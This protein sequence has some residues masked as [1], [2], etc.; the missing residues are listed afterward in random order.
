[1]SVETAF[2]AGLAIYENRSRLEALARRIRFRIK[3]GHLR[4]GVFGLG[5]TGKT[6][7]G[8][9]LVGVPRRINKSV[10]VQEFHLS[11]DLECTLLVAPGQGRRIELVWP[12]LF[13]SVAD[14]S[15]TGVVNVVS[16]GYHSFAGVGFRDHAAYQDGMDE[17]EFLLAYSS[18]RRERE[19]EALRTMTP[20]LKSAPGDLWMITLVT[21][22]D[23][24]WKDQLKV[25]DYY[26]TGEY[27]EL[28][29]GIRVSRGA[30]HFRHEYAFAS[31]VMNNLRTSDG[32]L[33][34]P[35][36][37]GYDQNMQEASMS[38]LLQV[39]WDLVRDRASHGRKSARK[40]TGLRDP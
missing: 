35:T 17:R 20:H 36:T 32:E 39:F 30:E 10:S 15:M 11:G 22:Q 8:Y 1:M 26:E 34:V 6:T 2:E 3:R 31:L 19:L 7:L 33:L 12:A 29:A 9:V 13:R 27:N 18:M 14:G 16:W 23:L 25:R 4:I 5:G 21:K 37:E 24:W 40:T 38:R 28:I